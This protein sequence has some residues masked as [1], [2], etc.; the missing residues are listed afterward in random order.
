MLDIL[1]F[2]LKMRYFCLLFFFWVKCNFG[3]FDYDGPS[4][5]SFDK[6]RYCRIYRRL[7]VV[8]MFWEK[9]CI[10]IVFGHVWVQK[11]ISIIKLSD[12]TFI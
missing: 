2:H 7:E 5:L 10:I 9:K 4:H 11:L 3:K 6:D 1:N 8:H 12:L